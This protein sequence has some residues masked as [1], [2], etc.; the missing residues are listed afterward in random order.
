V[1]FDFAR[2]APISRCPTPCC[3]STARR[4]GASASARRGRTSR[5]SSID[6]DGVATYSVFALYHPYR[7]TIDLQ[8]GRRRRSSPAAR[9]TLAPPPVGLPSRRCPAPTA[10]PAAPRRTAARAPRRRARRPLAPCARRRAIVVVEP[11]FRPSMR[12]AL[13][14]P[15]VRGRA[16]ALIPGRSGSPAACCARPP[17]PSRGCCAAAASARDRAGTVVVACRPP[18]VAAARTQPGAPRP[19]PFRAGAPAE[20]GS[21]GFSIA[22]QLGLGVLAHRHRPGHGGKD[23]GAPGSKT[24]EPRSVLDV[25]LRVETAPRRRARHRGRAD[26]PRRHF[27]P[28]EERTAIANRHGA[29]LFLSIHANSSRN[30]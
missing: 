25:A 21:G 6:L 20:N 7:L 11:C 8:P 18:A 26:A 28:L 23:P 22:R 29:D 5:A 30:R 12:H 13:T 3:S 16:P 10:A 15:T 14:P 1:F 24:H 9:H 4:C 27:I 19:R 17:D 2:T